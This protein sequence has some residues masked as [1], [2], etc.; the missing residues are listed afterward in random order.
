MID[1]VIHVTQLVFMTQFDP[2]VSSDYTVEPADRLYIIILAVQS[3][4]AE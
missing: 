1:H 4:V 3:F 2:L